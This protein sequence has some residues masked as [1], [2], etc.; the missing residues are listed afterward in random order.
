MCICLGDATCAGLRGKI[1]TLKQ[2]MFS[3]PQPGSRRRSTSL[4]I[5]L[6]IHCGVA[7]LWLHRSPVFVKPSSA[8]WGQHGQTENVTYFPAAQEPKAAGTKTALR[9]NAKPKLAKENPENVTAAARAGTEYGSLSQGISSGTEARPAL[10]LVFPDPVV[11][12]WQVPKG[13]QGDVIVEVTI[14]E[15]GAVTETRLLQSLEPGIDEKVVA[16]VRSWRFKPATV[17]GVAIS[18]RQDVHFHYPS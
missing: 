1:V 2:S 3:F 10:P 4:L 18:S 12:P 7:Y 17:D 15:Q 6:V 11:F 5:S 8:A 16:T 14:D 9:F 13:L